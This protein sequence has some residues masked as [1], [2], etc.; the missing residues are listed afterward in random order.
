MNVFFKCQD[1]ELKTAMKENVICENTLVINYCSLGYRSSIMTQRMM[2]TLKADKDLQNVKV[3]N[4]EGSIFKWAEENKP[5]KDHH[6]KATSFVHPFSSKFALMT[7]SRNKWKWSS[8][9]LKFVKKL[10][11]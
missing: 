7:L 4:M 6:G 8:D 11:K 2:E 9:A 1:N 5:L 10:P 3:L